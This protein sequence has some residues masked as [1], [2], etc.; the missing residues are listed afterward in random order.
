MKFNTKHFTPQ[1]SL[2]TVLFLFIISFHISSQETGQASNN[3]NEFTIYV[4][5][6]LYPLDWQSP[7]AL[8]KSAKS[9]YFKTISVRDNYLLGHIAVGIKSPLLKSPLLIAQ[10]SAST[11]E[12]LDLLFKQK[13]GLAIMGA[14]LQ[15][16]LETNEE[17]THKLNV[18]RKRNKLA[19]IRYRISDNAVKRMLTFIDEYSKKMNDKNAPCDFYGGAFWPGYKNEGSG[20]SAFGMALLDLVNLLPEKEVKIW[21]VDVNLPM[22]L[23]GGEYNN[24]KKIKTAAIKRADYWHNGVGVENVDY[25]K[26]FSYEPSIMFNWIHLKRT[27]NDSVY[28]PVEEDGA[29][30]LLVDGTAVQ[31]D[32]SEPI[33]RTRTEPNLF[34]EYYFRKINQYNANS[35]D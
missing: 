8:F 11:Q 7:S 3:K 5:P 32:E 33:F 12:K 16:R 35:N 10:A 29:P 34:V 23:I 26:H 31:F 4:M 19:F 14:P 22:T 18:Y 9:C 30:G 2:L 27:E 25:V 15:G 17:L 20:C 28:T 1:R 13:V 6:S 21:K 24:K